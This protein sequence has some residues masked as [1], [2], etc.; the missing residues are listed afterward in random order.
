MENYTPI[1]DLS[2]QSGLSAER[3]FWIEQLAELG[4]SPIL[5]NVLYE[6]SL[7]ADQGKIKTFLESLPNDK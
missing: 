6:K 5:I 7:A 3:H 2:F 1:L 4:L